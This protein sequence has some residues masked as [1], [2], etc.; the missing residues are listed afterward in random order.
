VADESKSSE[1]THE[2][3]PTCEAQKFSAL[4]SLLDKN[5]PELEA[6]RQE[7]AYGDE[8]DSKS[9]ASPKPGCW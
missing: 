1:D 9:S 2:E 7:D 8:F 4:L 5:V 6:W 3:D